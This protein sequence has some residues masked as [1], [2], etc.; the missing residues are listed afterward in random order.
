MIRMSTTVELKNMRRQLKE[1]HGIKLRDTSSK[2]MTQEEVVSLYRQHFQDKAEDSDYDSDSDSE[3][4]DDDGEFL[5]LEYLKAHSEYDKIRDIVGAFNKAKD[6]LKKYA[7]EN[8]KKIFEVNRGGIRGVIKYR[9][10]V[11]NRVSVSDLPAKIKAKYTKPSEIWR[12]FEN[13]S[14]SDK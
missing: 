1:I 7:Q 4:D 11:M 10:S 6:N 13:Y 14:V 12:L 8:D 2:K 9:T 5:A 3:S